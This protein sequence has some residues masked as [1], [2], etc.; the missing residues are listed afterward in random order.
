[1]FFAR[2]ATA[3]FAFRHRLC[4]VGWV[5]FY[6]C[7]LHGFGIGRFCSTVWVGILRLRLLRFRLLFVLWGVFGVHLIGRGSLAVFVYIATRTARLVSFASGLFFGLFLAIAPL[8]FGFRFADLGLLQVFHA[9]HK[10]VERQ[11]AHLGQRCFVAKSCGLCLFFLNGIR[12]VCFLRFVCFVRF[13]CVKGGSS[14][15][16][17]H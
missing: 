14:D 1:M 6:L 8:V 4:L 15:F 11:M 13:N 9:K 5:G 3:T 2:T 12:F 7:R 16:C 10:I 17:M